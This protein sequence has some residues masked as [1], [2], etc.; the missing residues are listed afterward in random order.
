MHFGQTPSQ[1]FFK[2]H[3]SRTK[4]NSK[5]LRNFKKVRM[6]FCL[7]GSGDVSLLYQHEG[8]LGVFHEYRVKVFNEIGSSLCSEVK[9]MRNN[10]K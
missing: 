8:R 2:P 4:N 7:E 1:I 3:P 5:T 6:L 10:S 9:L